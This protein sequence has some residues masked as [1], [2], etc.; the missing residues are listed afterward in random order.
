[1]NTFGFLLS[2]SVGLIYF[3]S[4][5]APSSAKPFEGLKFIDIGCGGGLLSEVFFHEFLHTLVGI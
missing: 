3:F 4:S 5:K 2:F 1:V